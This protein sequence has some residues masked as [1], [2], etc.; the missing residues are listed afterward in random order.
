MFDPARLLQARRLAGRTKRSVAEELHVSPTAVSQWESGVTA[1]RPDHMGRLADFLGVP[2]EFL[3]AG[4]PYAR[5]EA[6]AAHF[7]SLRSTPARERDKAIAFTEQVWELTFALEKRVQ[8]PPVN[9]PGF[10][11]G[12]VQHT[13]FPTEPQAAA[14]ALRERWGL[15]TGPIPQMVRLME[16]HGIV[17]TLVSFA[18]GATKSVDAF[19]TSRLPRPVVVLTPDRANDVY[20]HR[21]TAAHELGHLL[22]HADDAPGD[23]VREKEADKFAAEFLT[24]SSSIVPSLPPRM[25]LAA[26]D[27]LSGEWGVSVDSLVY[28]C[29]EVGSISESTYRRAFQRLNQLRQ[30]GLFRPQPATAHPGEVPA[31]L[32]RAFDVAEADGFTITELAREMHCS[33]RRVRMLLGYED[34]RPALKPI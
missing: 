8:F 24:P 6:D 26:L 11:G 10:T 27:V 20:R 22:L 18:G 4:R 15:G 29:R 1:P 32:S 23:P 16:K 28:R 30:V 21:F 17:A 31:L 34:S 33:V 12:E 3:T 7:R 5:L 14:R 2:V 25:D 9:L 13:D 19:S